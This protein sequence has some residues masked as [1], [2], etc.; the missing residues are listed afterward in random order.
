MKLVQ[1]AAKE[2]KVTISNDQL[3]SLLISDVRSKDPNQKTATI[4]D[5][6]RHPS[7]RRRSFIIFFDWFVNSMTYYGLSWNTSNLGGNDYINFV[8]SGAVEIPAYTFLLLTLN[9]WGRKTILCG[10]MVTAGVTLLLPLFVPSGKLFSY[11]NAIKLALVSKLLNFKIRT[12][13]LPN[14]VKQI[15]V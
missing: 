9:R 12:L 14:V 15:M 7:L 13:S 1:I 4:V 8:I 6:F 11:L 2:N 10:C 3:E 5:I